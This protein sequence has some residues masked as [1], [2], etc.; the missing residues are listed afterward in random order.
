MSIGITFDEFTVLYKSFKATIDASG[1]DTKI[2]EE[3]KER[4]VKKTNPNPFPWVKSAG[5][6]W[7]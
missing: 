3:E 7:S 4:I 5:A 6:G 2:P 1:V